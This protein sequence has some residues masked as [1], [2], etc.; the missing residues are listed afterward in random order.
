MSRSD[1]PPVVLVIA[2]NDPSGGAGI[3]ADIQ[4]ISALGAHPAPVITALTVQDTSNAY[5]VEPVDPELVSQQLETV[6]EDLPV[7][8]VKIGLLATAGICEAVAQVLGA[9]TPIPV[10]LDP[11]LVAAGGAELAEQALREVLLET[12]LPQAT[13]LTPNAHEIRALAP[14]QASPAAGA[15]AL[16]ARGCR[17]VLVKG[18]DADTPAVHNVL[19]D[20]RGEVDRTTWARLPHTY[21][22]SGC[23][24]ASAIAALLAAG[25]NP[26]TA[27]ARAERYTW[28]ALRHGFRPGGGQYVPRRLWQRTE[29]G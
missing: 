26:V 8:A 22:G 5:R 24:L 7:A 6:L 17:L 10:V 21:H 4:A 11:V 15:A 23:T 1:A 16:L 27:V 19:Y 18:A 25:E 14:G 12:L 20:A 29:A 9:A 13:I 3:G 2:G 28:E